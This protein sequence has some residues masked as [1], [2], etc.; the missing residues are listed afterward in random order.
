MKHPEHAVSIDLE[1]PFHDVDTLEIVWHGHYLK[2]AE[3]GRTA[4]MRA[5]QLDM[6]DLRALGVGMV[7]VDVQVRHSYPLRYGDKFRVTTWCTRFDHRINLAFA[8]RHLAA[9]R[10][11]ARGQV[12]LIVTDQDARLMLEAPD[13]IRRRL[14]G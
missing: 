9:D 12:S 6:A 8:I 4:L 2:Y 14:L 1:V 13:E 5:R 11:A 7:V 10:V 3:I